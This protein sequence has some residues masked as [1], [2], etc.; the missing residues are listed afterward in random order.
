MATGNTTGRAQHPKKP[1]RMQTST[2]MENTTKKTRKRPR[3]LPA[4]RQNPRRKK[5]AMAKRRRKGMSSSAPCRP[6]RQVLW[7]HRRMR[8]PS[9]RRW[10]CRAKSALTRT[11]P[12]T[13]C[14]GCPAWWLRCTRNWASGLPR[15]SCWR[16]CRARR[17]QTSA[18]NCRPRKS[19]CRWREQPTT[20]R[21][22]CG[23][24]A[25]LPSR[26]TSRPGH[27]CRKPRSPWPM[28]P[29]NCLP[30]VLAQAAAA[31]VASAAMS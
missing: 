22:S 21:R 18:A 8:H 30:S 11:A 10:C 24:S 12:R 26:T 19:A 17:F 6:R 9:A 20:A 7:W 14:P 23:R 5:R 1:T 28:P 29:R 31:L 25:S 2:R 13:W 4:A 15:G 16:W 3:R 27:P